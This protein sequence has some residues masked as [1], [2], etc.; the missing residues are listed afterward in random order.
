MYKLS[1]NVFP[2]LLLLLVIA[3]GCTTT[4]TTNKTTSY[5]NY[6]NFVIDWL[7]GNRDNYTLRLTSELDQ[8]DDFAKGDIYFTLWRLNKTDICNHLNFYESVLDN[9]TNCEERGVVYETLASLAESCNLNKTYYMALAKTEW[10]KCNMSWRN[11]VLDGK[12]EFREY[13]LPAVNLSTNKTKI[14]IGTSYIKI[15]KSSVIGIQNERVTRDWLTGQ[16]R[17]SPFTIPTKD[18]VYYTF[19]EKLS[20]NYSELRPDIG[21]HEGGRLKNILNSS[22]VTV[23]PVVGTLVK[24]INGKWFAPDENGVF[25]FHVLSDKVENYPTV[26]FLSEDLGTMVDTHGISSM[27]EQSIRNNVTFVM[28]CCDS[29]GK[30][31]AAHYLAQHGIDVYCLTDKYVYTLLGVNTTNTI[32]GSAPIKEYDNY[33][34]IGNQS[35]V[36]DLGETV[37]AESTEN[38]TLHYYGTP[39]AY[40]NRMSELLDNKLKIIKVNVDDYGQTNKLVAAA[41]EGNSTLIAAR[42]F[43]HADYQP[44]H[45]WLSEDHNNRAVLFHSVSY[46]YGYLLFE[47]FPN[48]TSFGDTK[49]VFE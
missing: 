25:K 32:V 36:M 23:I 30:V 21:W 45:D 7:E 5:D 47:E 37:V 39:Y 9:S 10:L 6:N 17:Y 33:V 24:K 19:Y 31:Y 40:F 26:R 49:M 22:N 8:A 14:R 38:S 44:L 34:I 41:K 42:V 18:N 15:D 11:Q 29:E 27:V 35:I 28:G 43:N 16:M 20:Y 4:E 2:A 46:P 48:Q 1:I 13:T 3:L 12:T